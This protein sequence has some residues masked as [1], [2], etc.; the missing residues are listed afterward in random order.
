MKGWN[1]ENTSTR[2][3]LEAFFTTPQPLIRAC[4]SIACE[5]CFTCAC[6]RSNGIDTHRINV[7]TVRVGRALV[8]ICMKIVSYIKP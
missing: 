7:T 1:I 6:V 5:S 3:V 4:F 8:D 2:I